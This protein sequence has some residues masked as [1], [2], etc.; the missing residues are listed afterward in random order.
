[1]T[2]RELGAVTLGQPKNDPFL[3][4]LIRM[5]EIGPREVRFDGNH[6]LD[7]IEKAESI[8]KREPSLLDVPVPVQIYGDLHGF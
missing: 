2:N 4:T 3:S 8:F 1:M 7:I 6:L 5:I